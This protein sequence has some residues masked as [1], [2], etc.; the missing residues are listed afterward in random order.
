[1]SIPATQGKKVFERINSLTFKKS[2]DMKARLEEAI[3]GTIGARQ[4]MVR[5]SR[6]EGPRSPRGGAG[7]EAVVAVE[8]PRF[9]APAGH[10]QGTFPLTHART[11]HA[12]HAAA[13]A[14]ASSRVCASAER[15]PFGNQDNVRW[16]KSVTHWRQPSDRVDR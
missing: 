15:S 4:E 14:P 6:G 7:R 12:P 16:R 1:M 13:R 10:W 3:L 5:R 9:H 8:T 11:H 2:L